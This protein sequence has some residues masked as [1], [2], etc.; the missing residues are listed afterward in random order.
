MAYL[1][2]NRELFLDAINQTS[3]SASLDPHVVEKDYYVTM[4]LKLVSQEFSYIVFKGGTSIQKAYG[5][6][7]R[8]SEDIDITIDEHIS[9]KEKKKIK[10][11][12]ADVCERLGL[13]ILNLDDIRSSRD[14][15]K[16]EIAYT[17][18]LNGTAGI[19]MPTVILE[20]SYTEVSF[21]VETRQIHNYIE[22][23]LSLQNQ[24]IIKELDLSVFEMKVQSLD[25]SLVDKVFA[26]GDYYLS[27]KTKRYSRHI[28]DIYKLWPL[29]EKNDDFRKL[30]QDVRSERA[31]KEICKSAQTGVYMNELLNR[32]VKDEIFR[33]DYEIL[34]SELLEESI[35]Y[36]EAITAIKEIIKSNYFI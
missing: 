15:N 17:S 30:I 26:L 13:T 28:Y 27:G 3:L 5:A 20:T 12:I 14:Y 19:I 32:I 10:Y 24:K 7:K 1:H 31:K 8:F 18:V 33:E 21:P 22:K 36:E 11:G 16:Y 35:S 23:E 9:R 2:E 4:I 25:R 29:V 6:I 34:T